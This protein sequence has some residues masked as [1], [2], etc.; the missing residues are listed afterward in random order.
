MNIEMEPG[1]EP[2]WAAIQ[3]L[4]TGYDEALTTI[5][6]LK[7]VAVELQA[8]LSKIESDHAKLVADVLGQREALSQ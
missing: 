1:S 4:L 8:Q 2:Y 7:Q 5:A 3:S 6:H